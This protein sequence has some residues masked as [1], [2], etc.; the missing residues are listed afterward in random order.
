MDNLCATKCVIPTDVKNTD[1]NLD[2][3]YEVL[4]KTRYNLLYAL[5]SKELLDVKLHQGRDVPAFNDPE[6]FPN[7]SLFDMVFIVRD[8][9]EKLAAELSY[10]V[11]RI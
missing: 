10:L 9:S 7:L 6:L 1:V 2:S 11:S 8:L 4:S 5:S 3:I